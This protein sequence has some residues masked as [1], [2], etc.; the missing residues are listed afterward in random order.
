MTAANTVTVEEGLRLLAEAETEEH[1]MQRIID[2][3]RQ[4]NWLVYHTRSSKGSEPGFPDLV[5]LKGRKLVT[6][7]VKRERKYATTAQM[8]WLLAF[9][10]AGAEALAVHPSDWNYIRRTLEEG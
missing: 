7:E 2:L 6:W 10:Q 5:L 4:L 1:F 9:H 8:G 3:A